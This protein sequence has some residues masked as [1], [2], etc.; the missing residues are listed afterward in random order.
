MKNLLQTLVKT[1]TEKAGKTQKMGAC[2]KKSGL[3]CPR[4]N[5]SEMDYDSL[6]NLTC[7][8][9]GYVISGSYT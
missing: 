9:C 3:I 6:L 5:H 2:D 4:C 7:K 8:S 1:F